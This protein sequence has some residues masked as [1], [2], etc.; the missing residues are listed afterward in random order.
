MSEEVF[1]PQEAQHG[2]SWAAGER[3]LVFYADSGEITGWDHIWVQDAL[4]MMVAM[5]RRAGLKKN[6]EK[7]KFDGLYSWIHL[8]EVE[9]RVV[10]TT[11]I[12]GRGNVQGEKVDKGKFLIVWCDGVGAITEAK[13]GAATWR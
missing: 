3:N 6:M 1:R 8:K 5:F 7:I 10:Q 13:N 4:S 11:R 9:Q 2:L 12:M